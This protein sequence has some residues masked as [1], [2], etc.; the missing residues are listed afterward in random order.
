M[1]FVY[2]AFD[3]KRNQRIAIKAAKPGYYR[4]LS[5]ELQGALQVRHPNV[6]LVNEIHTTQTAHGEIDFLTMELLEG[7]TLAA[8]LVADGKLPDDEAFKIA[9]QICSGL[10]S[11]HGER[12]HSS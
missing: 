3:R 1:G 9:C 4:L 7:E 11:A 8:R 2:E 6:C 12:C 10:A 5:P